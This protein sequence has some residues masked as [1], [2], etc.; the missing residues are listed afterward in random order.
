MRVTAIKTP[1]IHPNDDLFA[2]L[3]DSLPKQIPEK[4]VVAVTSKIVALC[5]GAVVATNTVDKHELVRRHAERYIDP[6]SSK[7]DVMLTVKHSVLAVNAG[8]DESNSEDNYVLWPSSPQFSANQIWEWLR[9]TYSVSE[10]GVVLT[11]SK[12]FPLKW[13]VIGTCLAHAGFLALIDRRGTPDV[14]DRPLKMTQVNAAEA[15]AVAAVFEM[16]EANEQT[17]VALVENVEKVQFQDR[18]PTPA[19]L[20]AITN[21]FEDDVYAPIL[22]KADWIA[23]EGTS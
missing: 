7:Y 4:S 14:F 3:K 20:E 2:I 19:E 16:G 11:D 13:G 18:V 12:T 15:L 21:V 9:E 1:K 10:V 17:P 23:G 22:L 5:E 8:I 6:H